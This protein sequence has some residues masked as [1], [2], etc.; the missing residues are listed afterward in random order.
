MPPRPTLHMSQLSCRLFVWRMATHGFIWF[1]FHLAVA[2]AVAAASGLP[3]LQTL[4]LLRFRLS[5]VYI[6]AHVTLPLS[7]SNE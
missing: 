1:H 3:F 7:L 6:L 5:I 2:V 4:L